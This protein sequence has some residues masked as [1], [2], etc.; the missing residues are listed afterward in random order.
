[1]SAAFIKQ[2]QDTAIQQNIVTL[3]N[4]V[5]EL[6]VAEPLVQRQGLSRIVVQ[7]PGAQDPANPQ[8][9]SS[10]QPR[11]WSFVLSART[12]TLTT[13]SAAAGGR[14]ARSSFTK[15]DG[16]PVLLKRD[17]IASGDQL[18]D[19]TVR[20]L[21]TNGQPAVF[22]KLNAQA[23]RKMLKTTQ[24]NFEKPMAVLFIEE[25]CEE[26]GAGDE[27]CIKPRTDFEVISIANIKGVFGT[28]F[29]ITGLT[30]AESRELALLLRAG[31]L[32]APIYIVEE[33]TIGPSLGKQN[34]D[35]GKMAITDWLPRCGRL[36][37]DL[38][39]TVRIGRQPSRCLPTSC[40][41][42]PRYRCCRRC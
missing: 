3:R 32:A 28:N 13:R 4:R 11:R 38:L 31:S 8:E 35:Q 15:D 26:F 33:R 23:G 16:A 1:M 6:G 40:C 34:V 27:G 25:K 17:I 2:R 14:L 21:T 5:N 24:E 29:Q 19:A 42:L 22:V 36:Y 39:S 18:T 10:V 20:F 7:L 9:D 12:A 41:S 37:V 30:P